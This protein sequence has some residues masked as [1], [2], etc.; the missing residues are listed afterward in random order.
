[1]SIIVENGF[2]ETLP[3]PDV[4]AIVTEFFSD[5]D[6]WGPGRTIRSAQFL[7]NRKS[8]DVASGRAL[9]MIIGVKGPLNESGWH[10]EGCTCARRLFGEDQ[11]VALFEEQFQRVWRKGGFEEEPLVRSIAT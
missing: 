6:V 8:E 11:Y 2:H 7:D 10:D 4:Q 5:A 1:V 3:S 9:K